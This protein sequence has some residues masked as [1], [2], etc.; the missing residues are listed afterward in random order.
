MPKA[1]KS[2]KAAGKAAVAK[3][4][5]GKPLLHSIKGGKAAPTKAPAAKASAPKPFGAKAATK[6]I[7]LKPASAGSGHVAQTRLHLARSQPSPAIAAYF[8]TYHDKTDF[9]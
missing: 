1:D 5:K 6:P 7:P 3:A 4:N 2:A 8:K 9:D